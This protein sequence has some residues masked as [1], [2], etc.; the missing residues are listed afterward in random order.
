MPHQIKISSKAFNDIQHAIDYYNKVQIGLGKK[1]NLATELI[2]NQ[3]KNTPSSGSF[4]YDNVRYRVV[5]QFPFIIVYEII[6]EKYIYVYRIF[7][8]SQ[9]PFWQ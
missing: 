6:E 1:F 8:T 9:N 7:N 2:L 5:K 3:L 4:L